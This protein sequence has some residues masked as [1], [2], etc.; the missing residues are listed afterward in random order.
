MERTLER[1]LGS[2]AERTDAPHRIVEAAKLPRRAPIGKLFESVA[3]LGPIALKPSGA[4]TRGSAPLRGR[5]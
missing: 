5:V 2:R 1:T 4:I 3:W